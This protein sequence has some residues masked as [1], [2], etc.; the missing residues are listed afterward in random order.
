MNKWERKGLYY[1]K[2]TS[3]QVMEYTLTRTSKLF[4]I[5]YWLLNILYPGRY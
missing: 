4:C 1:Y 3:Y 5:T 2:T